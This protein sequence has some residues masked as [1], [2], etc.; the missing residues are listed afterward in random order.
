MKAMASKKGSV[1]IMA[2]FVLSL[3][4]V[5]AMSQTAEA[6]EHCC[7]CIPDPEGLYE[8]DWDHWGHW[9]VDCKVTDSY[10][11]NPDNTYKKCNDYGTGWEEPGICKANCSADPECEGY[12]PESFIPFC[13]YGED[14][15]QDYCN[16]TCNLEDDNCEDDFVGCTADPVCD[17]LIPGTGICD[18]TCQT[19][20]CGDGSV[21]PGEE[22]ELPETMDNSNCDQTTTDCNNDNQLGI[23]DAFGDCDPECGCLYDDFVYSCVEGECGAECDDDEDCPGDECSETYY[24]GCEGVYLYDYNDNGIMDSLTVTDDCDDTCQ[25]DCSCSD[26]EVDCSPPQIEGQCIVGECGVV[27]ISD[28]LWGEGHEFMCSGDG[29]Y[30]R[31]NDDCGT[32]YIDTEECT[33]ECGADPECVGVPPMTDLDACDLYGYDYLQDYCDLQCK[34]RDDNCEDG[35]GFEGGGGCKSAH[36]CDEMVPNTNDCTYQCDYKPLICIPDPTGVHEYDYWTHWGPDLSYLCDDNNTYWKC[37]DDGLGWHHVN[38]CKYYC[39]ADEECDGLPPMTYLE[40]CNLT[41]PGYDFLQD[42]CN[43]ICLLEDNDCESDYEGCTSDPECDEAEPTADLLDDLCDE[44]CSYHYCGDFRMDQV[45]GEQC[46]PPFGV[47]PAYMNN[48]YCPQ[49]TE[50]C[51]YEGQKKGTRDGYGNCGDTCLCVEDPFSY[52]CVEGECGALCDED[53][54]YMVIE[55]DC[56]YNCDYVDECL[57]DSSCSLVDYCDENVYMYDGWCESDG[58]HFLSDDC[59]GYDYTDDWTYYC[60]GDDIRRHKLHHEFTCTPTGCEEGTYWVQDELVEDC[61][62][63]DGW[64]NFGNVEGL[65]DPE[66][67]YRDYTC[68]DY[69]EVVMCDYGVTDSN[70]YDYLDGAYCM[71]SDEAIEDRDYYCGSDGLEYYE[72]YNYHDCGTEHWF[73][74]GNTD[75]YNN[76]P[77]CE[78]MDYWCEDDGYNDYCTGAATYFDDYDWMD[79]EECQ[80]GTVY[81]AEHDFYCN[82]ALCDDVDPSNLCGPGD[83]WYNPECALICGADCDGDECCPPNDCSVLYQDSCEGFKLKDWNGNLVYDTMLVED[84]CENYCSMMP[85]CVCSDCEIDCS[86]TPQGTYCVE[87]VCDAE[88]DEDSDCLPYCDEEVWMHSGDCDTETDCGCDYIPEDCDDYDDDNN[89][90]HWCD[91]FSGDIFWWYEDWGCGPEGCQWLYEYWRDGLYEDCEDTCEDTDGGIVIDVAGTV[92]D[93]ELCD[94][95]ESMCPYDTY[96]DYCEEST[97]LVEYYCEDNDAYYTTYDCADLNHYG[98]WIYYCEGDSIYKY[99]VEYTYTCSPGGCV[100]HEEDVDHQE[101]EDCNPYDGWYNY[102]NDEGLNDPECEYRD[103]TCVVEPEVMCD[104]DV[105][106]SHDYDYMDGSYC[107]EQDEAVEDR[108]YYCGFDGAAYYVD[109]GYH[110]CGTEYWSGGGNTD[111]Y[112]DDP[113]CDYTD[114]WCVDDGYDD[115]CDSGIT[116]SDDYDDMDAVE[117]QDQTIYEGQHDYYCDMEMCDDF[118]PSNLCG[119]GDAWYNLYCAV[120]CGADCEDDGCCPDDECSVEYQDDCEGH[121]LIDWNGNMVH[122]SMLVEDFVE[123]T[124]SGMPDC[125]CTEYIAD[126]S[127]YPY[128]PYCVPGVCGAECDGDEDCPGD[129]CEETYD[130]YCEGMRLVDYNGDELLNGITMSDECDDTCLQDCLCTDCE[131][132]CDPPEPYDYCVQGVCGAEC[133]EDLDCPAYLEDDYCWYNRDCEEDC[134]C[135]PGDSEYCPEPGTVDD[136][137]CY[138]GLQECTEEGCSILVCVLEGNEYCDPYEGCMEVPCIDQPDITIFSDGASDRT[139]EFPD[140]GASNDSVKVKIPYDNLEVLTANVDLTGLPKSLTGDN[141]VDT[142]VVNDV[143]GSMDDN[144]GPDGKAQPGETPCK[145]NDMKNA[146]KQFIDTVLDFPDNMVGLASYST[147]LSSWMALTDSIPALNAEVDTYEAYGKTCISCGINKGA[148]VLSSG[149]NEV[150]AMVLMTDGNANTCL[151]GACTVGQAKAEALAEALAAY[152]NHGISVY[153]V[154]F[155]DDADLNLMQTIANQTGGKFYIASETNIA[156]VYYEIAVE[157]T[158]N[159]PFNPWLDVGSDGDYQ[160]TYSGSYETT[161]SVDFQAELDSLKDCTC[162][163]C[164]IDG[165]DCIIDMEIFS[166]QSGFMLFDNLLIEVCIYEIPEFMECYSDQ[167]CGGVENGPWSEWDCDWSDTCDEEAD[168]VRER[169]VTTNVCVN[170]GTPESYCDYYDGVEYEYDTDS[171]DTDGLD[172]GMFR[173]CPEDACSG[174]YW[175]D[176]PDDG[177]DTCVQGTCHEYSCAY[178]DYYFDEYCAG[179]QDYDQDGVPDGEDACPETFGLD[180]NGCPDPC[181]GCAI[182]ICDTGPPTCMGD[183]TQCSPTICPADG[184]GLGG[185]DPDEMADY[186]DEVANTCMLEGEEGTCTAN[187]CTATCEYDEQ[188]NSQECQVPDGEYWLFVETDTDV[189]QPSDT[190]MITGQVINDECL[191]EEGLTVGLEAHDPLETV[192]DMG[193][194]VTD[195]NGEFGKEVTIPSD[196]ILGLYTLFADLSGEGVFNTTDFVIDN[197]VD[198]LLITEVMYDTPGTDYEEE[199]LELYN[200]TMAGIDLTGMRMYDNSGPS[201]WFDFPEMVLGPGEIISVAADRDGFYN[202]YGCYP[203]V[204]GFHR[205]LANENG[206]LLLLS[207]DGLTEVDFVAWEGGETGWD[208]YANT[209]NSIVRSPANKDTDLPSDWLSD[210]TPT[211]HCAPEEPE[212]PEAPVIDIEID[213]DDAVVSWSDVG[214][215]VDGYNVYLTSTF[216]SYGSVPDYELDGSTLEQ[217][218]PLSSVTDQTGV[219]VTATCGL[220]ESDYSNEVGAMKTT[221]Y[222]G[223][224]WV[225]IPLETDMESEEDLADATGS[226]SVSRWDPVSQSAET[227]ITGI[228]GDTFDVNLLEGYEVLMAS[229]DDWYFTGNVPESYPSVSLYT[230]RNWVG[231]KIGTTITDPPSFV[232]DIIP[233][234]LTLSRWDPV[235]QSA[236]TWI[237]GIGGDNFA[238]SIIEGYEV[239]MSGATTWVQ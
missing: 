167:D 151:A 101:V 169:L 177:Q 89:A 142:V 237:T 61:N 56:Y 30:S 42:F 126:C 31:C 82:L 149:T 170:P 218:I 55:S 140:G 119:P 212:P 68:Y 180:C 93:Y 217:A 219:V 210:Q 44:E 52:E 231:L 63:Y 3:F 195:S 50:D 75:E 104:Y 221:L 5:I 156:D 209:G 49:T 185:C 238:T 157:L 133:D 181:E 12:P 152:N 207:P 29:T 227:W 203:D 222:T 192:K 148:E 211:P 27:C 155:G 77:E 134:G 159:Y 10:C 182:M 208:I 14:Y 80:P 228:G 46:E 69:V 62:P 117:C 184:C 22:C 79:V 166:E 224:N 186:P 154:A 36:E 103:Y 21:D 178:L 174:D 115:Y 19:G 198:H 144:C 137:L 45:L 121:M 173:D 153:T 225:H 95:E 108:D 187:A 9:G 196:W 199:W 84:Y 150:R 235:S 132:N 202:L 71:D 114:Y 102:G 131:V 189:Y 47:D 158:T 25:Q 223:R 204:D 88:C 92:T 146:T 26:C 105:P 215:C 236:E 113:S 20:E 160:W 83:A 81:F 51:E 4:A 64:Y 125:I 54:D 129:S 164:M 139:V 138:Y 141:T 110:D 190:I 91:P 112:N 143:S 232:A 216:G 67:E 229:Q 97:I 175:Y 176:Y 161:E 147:A 230:G 162:T 99:R 171:R 73:G 193:Q 76:D 13:N 120:N 201:V 194:V 206:D 98:E 200:P 116:Y 57:Y 183:D 74:G 233:N 32:E 58:C 118:D 24:D 124:C 85:D 8:Y 33:E 145:I 197:P 7:V 205:P 123:N 78:Y 96:D 226:L 18:M 16:D 111:Q 11:C 48:I 39:S 100:V 53:S 38:I 65:N 6:C 23:R 90:G 60:E 135:S 41:D 214:G 34:L 213:G 35:V 109:S 37:D 188:C 136:N 72:D 43:E 127:A 122:D 86:A 87:G 168:C 191:G 179:L 172:C 1:A 28:G 107:M 106:E 66:C 59:S 70:D 130:D 15:L 220:L 17:E 239:L 40:A 128:G 163:G 165:S 234:P 2:V 94:D